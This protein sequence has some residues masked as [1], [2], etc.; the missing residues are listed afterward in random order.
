VTLVEV[1]ATLVLVGIV[2]PV[3]MH[4]ITLSMQAASRARHTT[5]AGQLAEAKLNELLVLRDPTTLTGSGDFGED[6]PEYRWTSAYLAADYNTYEVTVTVLWTERGQERS[7]AL[8][9]LIYPSSSTTI[10]GTL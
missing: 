8:T 5:E 10:G 3:A 9:T 7:V 1:L 6:W 4:G 2:L